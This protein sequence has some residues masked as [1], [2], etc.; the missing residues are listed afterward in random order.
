MFKIGNQ[1]DADS[2]VECT[3]FLAFRDQVAILDWQ[4]PRRG[5]EWPW[6]SG[7]GWN[8]VFSVMEPQGHCFTSW[9]Q[10]ILVFF[11][12]MKLS[13]TLYK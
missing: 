10:E 5:L 2:F 11:Y 8:V 12:I 7:A 1:S 6:V 9:L 4:V 13:L 3:Q